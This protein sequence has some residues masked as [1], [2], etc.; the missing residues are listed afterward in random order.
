MAD[1]AVDRPMADDFE[2]W[3][4]LYRG[5]ADF[6]DFPQSDEQAA[7]V[8]SWIHD[9]THEVDAIVVRDATGTATGLAHFRPFARPLRAGL[10][11]F[12]DD[13]YV[14]P[15]HRGTGAVDA[16]LAELR[17]IAASNG[18]D[19]VRWITADDNYRARTKYDQVA[20]R[21]TWITYDM[22]PDAP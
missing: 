21:T 14:D 8:W 10:G 2:R 4:E 19:V 17:T 7:T 11:C 13:L 1:W 3:R 16:L 9:P 20:M 12:L 18:W 15:A 5:Y 22:A 6:Y